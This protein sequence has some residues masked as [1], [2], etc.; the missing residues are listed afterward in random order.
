MDTQRIR[1]I[2]NAIGCVVGIIVSLFLFVSLASKVGSLPP[3]KPD[4]PDGGTVIWVYMTGIVFAAILGT[5]ALVSLIR[6][7]K[8]LSGTISTKLDHD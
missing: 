5:S 8:Y 4:D 3:P 7:M 1:Q 6:S 2:S